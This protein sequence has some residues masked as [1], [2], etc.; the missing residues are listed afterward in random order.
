LGTVGWANISKLLATARGTLGCSRARLRPLQPQPTAAAPPPGALRAAVAAEDVSC[1]GRLYSGAQPPCRFIVCLH[2]CCC[3]SAFWPLD[4]HDQGQQL[5]YSKGPAWVNPKG[6]LVLE[7]GVT[8]GQ[9]GWLLACCMAKL[10]SG[11]KQRL[12]NVWGQPNGSYIAA[13]VDQP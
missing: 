3:M 12:A 6:Q 1:A 9:R 11:G 10:I 8:H 7:W 2:A 4:M 13:R 5:L